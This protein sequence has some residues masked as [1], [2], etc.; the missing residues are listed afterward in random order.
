MGQQVEGRIVRG[1]DYDF[2]TPFIALAGRST[3][4][5]LVWY[6]PSSVGRVHRRKEIFMGRL[7]MF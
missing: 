1:Y 5:K 4:P 7:D 3:G 6:M 2:Y